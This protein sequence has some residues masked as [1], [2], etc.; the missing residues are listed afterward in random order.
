MGSRNSITDK[1]EGQDKLPLIKRGK[2]ARD[3]QFSGTHDKSTSKKDIADIK[4]DLQAWLNN[5]LL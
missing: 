5:Y 1:S 3:R 2:G 4:A